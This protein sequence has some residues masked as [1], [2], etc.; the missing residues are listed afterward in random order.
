MAS[1]V[2]PLL[3]TPL[4]TLTAPHGAGADALLA[5]DAGLP[6]PLAIGSELMRHALHCGLVPH[7]ELLAAVAAAKHAVRARCGGGCRPE[8]TVCA[9]R[10][11]PTAPLHFART[12]ELLREVLPVLHGEVRPRRPRARALPP[13]MVCP[14]PGTLPALLLDAAEALVAAKNA[15]APEG[16]AGSEAVEHSANAGRIVELL[17]MV[18]GDQRLSVLLVRG[19]PF[20]WRARAGLTRWLSGG[21]RGYAPRAGHG[22]AGSGRTRTYSGRRRRWHGDCD[23]YGGRCAGDGPGRGRDAAALGDGVRPRGR[24][25]CRCPP[26]PAS[27]SLR[28]R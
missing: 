13:P 3:V 12:L 4:R 9:Q 21:G 25:P 16:A 27:P 5:W 24:D 6:A 1:A 2:R 17:Q 26:R 10:C 7:A 22:G 20:A 23:A 15:H 19:L 28:P 11:K 14:Q 18:F 8:L